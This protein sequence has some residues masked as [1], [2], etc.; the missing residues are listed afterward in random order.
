VDRL[1]PGPTLLEKLLLDVLRDDTDGVRDEMEE[2]KD[3]FR[4][5]LDDEL[6]RPDFCK[7]SLVTVVL[8]PSE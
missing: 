7:R 5:K 8:S 6:A 1:C 3:L 2:E 4:V